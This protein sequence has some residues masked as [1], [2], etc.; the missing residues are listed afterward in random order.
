MT[1]NRRNIL[2]TFLLLAAGIALYQGWRAFWFLTDD[3]FIA[4][5][6]VSNSMLGYGYTWNPPPFRPVEGY[7]SFLWVA[8]LDLIW[9]TFDTAPPDIA[10]F[11]SL[12]F[13]YLTLALVAWVGLR[14][15][16]RPALDRQRLLFLFLILT[17]ILSNRTFLA[18]TSSGMETAMFN[19][20]FNLWLVAAAFGRGE[21]NR[22]LFVLTG[23]GALVYL[24]R[25]DG[26][27]VVLSS[28]LMLYFS[29]RSRLRD[30][31]LDKKWFLSASPLVVAPI[32]LLWRK[33]FYGEWLPNTFHA[34]VVAPWPEAGAKYI[35]SFAL[36]YG[37][38]VWLALLSTLAYVRFKKSSLFKRNEESPLRAKRAVPLSN[39]TGVPVFAVTAIAAL[40]A[41][42]GYYTFVV[43]G[44]HFEYR[45]YS[46]LIPLIFVSFLWMLNGSGLKPKAAAAWFALF[47][48]VSLPL[49]WVHWAR[50]KANRAETTAM[51][52]PISGEF[53][54]VMHVYT[55]PFDS[56]Q[57][58]LIKHLVCI[59]HQEHKIFY[60][61]H[62]WLY[63]SRTE[64]EKFQLGTFPVLATATVGVPGWA[65]PHAVILDE[66]GLNDYVIA[67]SPFRK[68]ERLMAH[69]RLPPP[70][71]VESFR[72]NVFVAAPG[73][74]AIQP[75]SRNLTDAYI[76]STETYWMN[77]VKIMRA[78]LE[79]MS[80]RGK[81]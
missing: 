78:Q 22:R 16:L 29:L 66:L 27:L 8:L 71:Y 64:G 63:P 15:N 65:L 37:L 39:R 2:L 58:W 12:G 45:I 44:D 50:M 3:A 31:A 41:Q 9:R 30:G 7:T 56:L 81:K 20:F 54:T 53:P 4:F 80:G 33:A 69:E 23:S 19:F 79:E 40:L 51:Q 24:C 11:L 77:E 59:R 1:L 28:L 49:P 47:L 36:E 75:P 46:H 43:G 52:T 61:Y 26:I 68:E 10:N 74:I 5:R 21:N 34:K 55:K 62:K 32:H 18:W 6:Y 25:P 70:G 35:L 48:L 67:R 72:P 76:I 73:K 14:M 60:E 42:A 57:E 13:S 38:G 17:G